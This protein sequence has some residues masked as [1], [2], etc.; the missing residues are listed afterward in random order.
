MSDEERQPARDTVAIRAV[1]A[2]RTWRSTWHATPTLLL[3]T[4]LLLAILPLT[5]DAPML[6]PVIGSVLSVNLLVVTLVWAIA[7]QGWN[8][9]A[10]F[11]GRFSF[12]HAAFFG[13]GAY[14]PIVLAAQYSINPWVGLLV[15]AVLAG[16]YALVIGLLTFRFDVRGSYFVLATLA[17]AELLLAVFSN[18]DELGGASGFVKPLPSRYG[19]EYGLAAFQFDGQLPYYYVGLG[20][21]LVV[22]LVAVVIKH[23][24][25]G[26]SLF[27]I[28]EDEDAAS[29]VGI[30]TMRYKLLALVVSAV[31]TAAAG[32]LW[33]MYFTTVRPRVVFGVLVNLEILVPAVVGGLGSVFGPIVGALGLT[34]PSEFGR[35]FVDV[36]EL[37][38]VVYGVL[39]LAIVLKSPD[40]I[41]TL[42]GK[43]ADRLTPN[44]QREDEG[45]E[46]RDDDRSDDEGSDDRSDDEGGDRSD[47][48]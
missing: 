44:R 5:L 19:A 15:G 46:D 38:D 1:A 25:A 45:G 27:A 10:G 31:C 20:L 35:S 12:G 11:V 3:A 22:T 18:V 16:L 21:L 4:F 26:L 8:V 7:G 24:G 14:A 2:V 36:P 13:L 9:L 34:V 41:V 47:D 23:S 42:P 40:G 17:F 29:A 30:P 6:G 33:G 28:R 48:D 32:T 43:L 37:Q 39:L